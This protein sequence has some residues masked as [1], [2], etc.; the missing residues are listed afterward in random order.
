MEKDLSLERVGYQ[1]NREMENLQIRVKSLQIGDE[2]VEIE[3]SLRFLFKKFFSTG[4][5]R[6]P[7]VYAGAGYSG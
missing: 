6:F 7:R 3:H 1:R 4:L 2:L 5:C